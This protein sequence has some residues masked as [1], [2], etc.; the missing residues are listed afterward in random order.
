MD[1][2]LFFSYDEIVR[3]L[4]P[5]LTQRNRR[6]RQ[7]AGARDFIAKPFR[8]HELLEVIHRNLRNQT[9]EDEAHALVYQATVKAGVS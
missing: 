4:R 8:P 1:L 5:E 9:G 6:L 7:E 2:A 3:P